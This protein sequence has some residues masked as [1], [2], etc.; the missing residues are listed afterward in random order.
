MDYSKWN[1]KKIIYDPQWL[2]DLFRC[3]VS[4]KNKNQIKDGMI[5]KKSIIK[6]IE[7][8]F[9]IKDKETNGFLLTCIRE[10]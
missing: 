7:N 5:E 3:I 10:I 4:L 8:E 6:N 1:L 2:A 9:E